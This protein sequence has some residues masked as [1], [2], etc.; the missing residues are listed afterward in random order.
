MQDELGVVVGDLALTVGIQTGQVDGG[1]GLR[2]VSCFPDLG[3]LAF[4][5]LVLAQVT[6]S[7]VLRGGGRADACGLQSRNLLVLGGTLESLNN[8]SGQLS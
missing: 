2:N 4:R 1:L 6:V 8:G 3:K 5:T 7:W